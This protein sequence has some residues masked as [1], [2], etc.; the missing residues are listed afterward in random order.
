V[1][2]REFAKLAR[3]HLM[4]HLPGFAF[5]DGRIY[6]LP[7]DRLLRGFTLYAS[8][9]SRARFTVY[10]SVGILY[11]PENVGAIT[12]GLGD[13]LPVL[14]GRGDQWWEWDD[15][16]DAE[17]ATATIADIRALILDVGVPF[18]EKLDTVEA[19]AERLRET[20]DYR[21]DPHVAEALAYS[22]VLT[23]DDHGAR[24]TLTLLRRLTLDDDERAGWWADLHRGTRE[25]IED[26]WVL[27]V[28]ERVPGSR[29]LPKTA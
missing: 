21:S 22:L 25:P 29:R 15:H 20:G 6:A 2:G 9:F 10:C 4:P 7:V 23:G 28:G 8:G 14:A 1:K 27:G 11:V 16:A 18:L 13:R 19:V 5:K 26:D 17:A 24:E 12:A 3:R